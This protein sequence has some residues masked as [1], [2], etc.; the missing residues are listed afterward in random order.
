MFS[1]CKKICKFGLFEGTHG[2][3]SDGI[4]KGHQLISTVGTSST[5]AVANREKR[6]DIFPAKILEPQVFIM[7]ILQFFSHA[8]DMWTHFMVC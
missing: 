2:F 6:T 5:H 8:D 3:T 7:Y 1:V 4:M